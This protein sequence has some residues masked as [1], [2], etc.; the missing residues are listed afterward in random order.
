[1]LVAVPLA[2][3]VY[4]VPFRLTADRGIADNGLAM[5]FRENLQRFF[6]PVNHKGPV[7]LYAYVIFGL[8]APW[9]ALLPAAMIHRGQNESRPARTFALVF[10]WATFLFFTL[11]A[12]RRRYYLLPIL[13]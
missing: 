3:E 2:R 12:S 13:P 6:N 5:V 11:S 9:S 10:F 8:F 1:M 7:Y 4:F